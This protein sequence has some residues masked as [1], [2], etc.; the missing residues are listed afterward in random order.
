MTKIR[1]VPVLL[2]RI[3][4][5]FEKPLSE[6]NSVFVD[7]TLG[8]G[9]HTEA[10]LETFPQTRGFV[11]DRDPQAMELARERLSQYRH[12]LT[13]CP[14]VFDEYQNY[15]TETP[16]A[17]LADLGLSSLQIDQPERGFSYSKPAPL[18]MRMSSSGI[19]A[20]EI[21]NTFDETELARIIYRFGEEPQARQIAKRIVANRPLTSSEQ[22][23]KLLDGL[24]FRRKG[25]PAKRIF[26]ALRIAVND[27]LTVLDA[28]L[29]QVLDSLGNC[30]RFAVLSYHSLEDRRVK[31]RFRNAT[32][33]KLPRGVPYLAKD[34]EP[35]Y[36][37]LTKKA[38]QPNS[39][40]IANNPRAASAKLRVIERS[41]KR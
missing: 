9:G 27:E 28:L 41:V 31:L 21:L 19:T 3:L 30:G 32:E 18:D 12:R 29:E 36:R 6:K 4:H 13:Y 8:L 24:Q 20:A 7:C 22:L 15:V 16:V 34:M 38:E 39:E 40:E 10:I 35:E 23:V 26:Q 1:H 14:A 25:H 11:F 5:F 17:V 37:I 2:D 33:V